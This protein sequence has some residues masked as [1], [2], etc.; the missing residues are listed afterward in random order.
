MLDA[1]S[2][3]IREVHAIQRERRATTMQQVLFLMVAAL[4]AAP[5]IIGLTV[6]IGVGFA[7]AEERV[8]VLPA[9]IG[10]IALAYV[11][12]QAFICAMAVGVIRYGQM[13]KGIMFTVPFMILTV[14]V[15]YGARI[16]MGFLVPIV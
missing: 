15:S 4:F 16:L 3:D 14:C 8:A 1:V 7:G 9:E 6:A 2:A 13:R 12:I 11:A 10:T 5:F